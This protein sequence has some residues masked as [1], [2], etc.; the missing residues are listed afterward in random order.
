MACTCWMIAWSTAVPAMA[1]ACSPAA[2]ACFHCPH[3]SAMSAFTASAVMRHRVLWVRSTTV[4]ASSTHSIAAV[5]SPSR[6]ST[7]ERSVST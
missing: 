4:R 3:V 7:I 1:I 2:M 5:R 6:R